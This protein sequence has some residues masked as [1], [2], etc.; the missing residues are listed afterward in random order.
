MCQLS[1][2]PAW[3]RS[4]L[5][6]YVWN[7]ASIL[8][9]GKKQANKQTKR[10][11]QPLLTV[12]QPSAFFCFALQ[13][14]FV[15]F[16]ALTHKFLSPPLFFSFT[17]AEIATRCGCNLS[18]LPWRRLGCEQAC[19]RGPVVGSDGPAAWLCSRFWRGMFRLARVISPLLKYQFVCPVADDSHKPYL[20]LKP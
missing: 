6:T 20:V 18:L 4:I 7:I 14:I 5:I 12:T 8:F 13:K 16:F 19:S 11:S 9:E 3:L 10:I 1:R 15:F 2:G 17:R